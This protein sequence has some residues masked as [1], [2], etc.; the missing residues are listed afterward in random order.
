MSSRTLDTRLLIGRVR[1]K[2][3][4]AAPQGFVSRR[5]N[6]SCESAENGWPCGDNIVGIVGPQTSPVSMQIA[7][8]GRLFTVPQV[9]YLATSVSLCN[10]AEFPYFF[11]TVPSDVH[12]ARVARQTILVF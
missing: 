1:Y 2:L 11:R 4:I 9:S 12:Q 3:R 7:N 6:L 5:M 8:L 10:T